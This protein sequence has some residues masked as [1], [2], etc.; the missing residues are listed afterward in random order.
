MEQSGIWFGVGDLPTRITEPVGSVG[1]PYTLTWINS[2]PPGAPLEG[3]TIV[4]HLYLDA[5][6]GPLI[7]TPAQRGLEGW[8]GSVI[9]WFAAP[10]GFI[11][12]LTQLGLPPQALAAPTETAP[13]TSEAAPTSEA[14]PPP[15]APSSAATAAPAI[16][17]A[18]RLADDASSGVRWGV[19]L[20]APLVALAVFSLNRHRR[21]TTNPGRRDPTYR[22][23]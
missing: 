7:H 18:P 23:R 2:G 21:Q 6:P 19:A 15:T 22:R 10:P 9:G 8:G 20:G 12:T 3:R 16:I 11:D 1:E 14:P 4:Q 13:P 17:A 5:A